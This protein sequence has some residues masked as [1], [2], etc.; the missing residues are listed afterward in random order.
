MKNLPLSLLRQMI[1]KLETETP[2]MMSCPEFVRF[3]LKN[4]PQLKKGEFS[5]QLAQGFASLERA[6][7][8]RA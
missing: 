6:P 1:E 8:R 3:I 5:E 4:R 7:N 2:S